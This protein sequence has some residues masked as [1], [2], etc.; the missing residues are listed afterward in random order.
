MSKSTPNLGKRGEKGD[1]KK[2]SQTGTCTSGSSKKKSFF[3]KSKLESQSNE[4]RPI[5]AIND[6][7]T[8]TPAYMNAYPDSP[9]MG[10]MGIPLSNSYGAAE[11]SSM[12][13]SSNQSVLS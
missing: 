13:S 11:L 7:Y 4:A 9:S 2:S 12:S 1:H 6:M 8:Y 5:D 3:E 10:S